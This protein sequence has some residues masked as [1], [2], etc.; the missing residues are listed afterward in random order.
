MSNNRCAQPHDIAVR[1]LFEYPPYAKEFFE[2]VLQEDVDIL[3]MEQRPDRII[4]MDFKPTITDILFDV[5][6]SNR[7]VRV[8]LMIEHQ[9]TVD[10]FLSVR[11]LTN[12]GKLW[13]NKAEQGASELP[14]VLSVALTNSLGKWTAPTDVHQLVPGMSRLPKEWADKVPQMSY[15]LCDL[16][17]MSNADLMEYAA[18]PSMRLSLLA[19]RNIRDKQLV[20]LLDEWKELWRAAGSEAKGL[21]TVRVV[22]G[23][24]STVPNMSNDT[25]FHA[26]EM[27][28]MESE[29]VRQSLAWQWMEEG[30]QKGIQK[31]LEQGRAEGLEKG[32]AKGL[33]KGREEG[34]ED[35]FRCTLLML[36]EARLGSVSPLVREVVSSASLAKLEVWTRRAV[37]AATVE[38]V[39][40]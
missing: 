12:V 4:G 21:H 32:L 39:F 14:V 8:Y 28:G 2:L 5:A 6:L 18:S 19:L 20:A 31:G 29:S 1:K 38:D 15:F 26:G 24:L 37:V 23:Y 30:E 11:M 33:A 25:L 10:R 40:F 36:L 9:S 27:A 7:H 22:L 13:L 16:Q 34:R 17:G 3:S 35:G